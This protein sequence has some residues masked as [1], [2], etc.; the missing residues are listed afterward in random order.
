MSLA[1]S[2]CR[3]QSH[4]PLIVE[5]RSLVPLWASH[6]E[7]PADQVSFLREVRFRRSC[8]HAR[9]GRE[10]HGDT[11]IGVGVGWRSGVVHHASYDSFCV[12][13]ELSSSWLTRNVH[14]PTFNVDDCD[15][16]CVC[17]VRRPGG[18]VEQEKGVMNEERS[19]VSS[20][21][22][23]ATVASLRSPWQSFCSVRP[24]GRSPSCSVFTTRLALVGRVCIPVTVLSL[25]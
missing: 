12:A 25:K 20:C 9:R 8:F 5:S 3:T 17:S 1:T 18:K 14:Q 13:L 15:T 16:H 19:D 10:K 2:C 24:L 21:K 4:L 11:T 23:G 22:V 7:M 6:C